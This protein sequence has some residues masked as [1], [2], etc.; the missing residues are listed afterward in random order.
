MASGQPCYL[1]LLL[2]H[3]PKVVENRKQDSGHAA[4]SSSRCPQTKH[5][6]RNVNL[7]M[8]CNHLAQW[9]EHW[10][11]SLKTHVCHP[12][13]MCDPGWVTWRRPDFPHQK[14]RASDFTSCLHPRTVWEMRGA[15]R[16]KLSMKLVLDSTHGPLRVH[17]PPLVAPP[18][19]PPALLTCSGEPRPRASSS[20]NCHGLHFP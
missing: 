9:R 5:S 14:S 12:W 8:F 11:R 10:A 20:P 4:W 6:P 1:D 18:P 17:S 3:S 19:T 16:C 7:R 13:L 2:L 15:H